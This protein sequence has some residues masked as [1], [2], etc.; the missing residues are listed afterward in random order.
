M[1]AGRRPRRDTGATGRPLIECPAMK[2]ESIFV[3]LGTLA[4]WTGLVL[5]LT[6]FRRVVAVTAGRVSRGAFKVGEAADLPAELKLPNRNLMN[7]L[8]MPQ[9]FYVVGLSFFVTHQVTPAVVGLAWLFVALRLAH[10]AIHLTYNHVVH[11]LAVFALSNFVLLTL[12][13]W[14]ITRVV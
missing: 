9:L 8:E 5:F 2:P 7:L 13:I 1:T 4:I 12:W 3:P 6:G 14:L 10:S 11:R